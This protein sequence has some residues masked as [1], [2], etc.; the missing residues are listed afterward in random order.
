MYA[1]IAAYITEGEEGLSPLS[2]APLWEGLMANG[3]TIRRYTHTQPL[4]HQG[5]ACFVC[6][7]RFSQPIFLHLRTMVIMQHAIKRLRRRGGGVLWR[8]LETVAISAHVFASLLLFTWSSLLS[9]SAFQNRKKT[10]VLYSHTH[11]HTKSERS[12]C[13]EPYKQRFIHFYI[14]TRVALA[15]AQRPLP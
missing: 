4:P 12:R 1:C 8:R 10:H 9:L 2:C 7:Y 14:S 15:A 5:K 3:T 6:E 13:S 11:A